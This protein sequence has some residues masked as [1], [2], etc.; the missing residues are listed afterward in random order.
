MAWAG[1]TGSYGEFIARHGITFPTVDDT[2]GDLFST[3]RVSGQPA[4]AFVNGDK[5]DRAFGSLSASDIESRIESLVS[6]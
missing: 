5:I 6:D 3:F 1:N 4:F 2:S